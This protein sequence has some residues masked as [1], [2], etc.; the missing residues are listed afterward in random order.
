MGSL[1]RE[2]GKIVSDKEFKNAVAEFEAAQRE[3]KL[4]QL[5]QLKE[6]RDI[7]NFAIKLLEEGKQ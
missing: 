1:E 3:L 7:I 6:A 4:A 5:A 2:V